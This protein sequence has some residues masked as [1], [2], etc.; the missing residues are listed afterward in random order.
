M[1]GTSS[2]SL[3][4]SLSLCVRCQC[5]LFGKYGLKQHINYS[6]IREISKNIQCERT[7]YEQRKRR[8]ANTRKNAGK[9]LHSTNVHDCLFRLLKINL[10]PNGYKHL[11]K[12][13]SKW[14]AKW[15]SEL[16]RYVLSK[17][18]NAHSRTHAQRYGSRVHL[19]QCESFEVIIPFIYVFIM[20][21]MNIFEAAPIHCTGVCKLDLHYCLLR[22]YNPIEIINA[23]LNLHFRCY[24][25]LLKMRRVESASGPHRMLGLDPLK[26]NISLNGAWVCMCVLAPI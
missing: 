7:Q 22:V 14:K 5:D 12:M 16:Q 15:R 20:V 8:P 1:S 13:W 4:L 24:V 6:E 18:T 21:I 2:L 3:S 11:W 17:S 10:L 9:C 19:S 26:S 23:K 25:L